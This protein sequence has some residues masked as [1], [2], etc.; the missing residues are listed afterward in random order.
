MNAEYL[1]ELVET[2]VAPAKRGRLLGFLAS[3]RRYDDFLDELLHDPKNFSSN[4]V[5]PLAAAE[6]CPAEVERALRALGAGDRAYLIS[7]D[8]FEDGTEGAL[9]QLLERHV[10]SDRDVLVYCADAN[11]GYYEGHEGWRY[12]LRS[13]KGS[14]QSR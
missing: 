13:P 12:V 6:Q 2:L 8:R 4:C 11:V 14:R 7:T 9:R 1:T 10:G 3:A 5:V